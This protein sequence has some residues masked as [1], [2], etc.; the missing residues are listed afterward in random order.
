M[1]HYLATSV[2]F[3]LLVKHGPFTR[4]NDWHKK[5]IR[6]TKD[7]LSEKKKIKSPILSWRYVQSYI[8]M[9]KPLQ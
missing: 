9:V 2:G 5:N 3:L 4:H 7:L 8:E 1:V 6:F